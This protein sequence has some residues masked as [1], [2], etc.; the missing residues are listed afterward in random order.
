MAVRY[1][2]Y[3]IDRVTGQKIERCRRIHREDAQGV[4]ESL[5]KYP[6]TDAE[7]EAYYEVTKV[8]VPVVH[9]AR[10]AGETRRMN[11]RKHPR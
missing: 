7:R 4:A 11:T 10:S 3:Q 9:H 6:S 5:S 2:V 1:V 8:D